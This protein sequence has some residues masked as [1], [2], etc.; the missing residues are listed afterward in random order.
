MRWCLSSDLANSN[1][2]VLI[3]ALQLCVFRVKELKNQALLYREMISF[4]HFRQG[5]ISLI[6]VN[7]YSTPDGLIH[8]FNFR[9]L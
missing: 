1:G 3:V 9:Y 7:P 4:C 6:P 2:I 8:A 5:N